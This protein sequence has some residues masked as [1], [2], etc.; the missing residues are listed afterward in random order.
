M[1]QSVNQRKIDFEDW[2]WWCWCWWNFKLSI[3]NS[4][5]EYT[6]LMLMKLLV[7]NIVFKGE[8][9]SWLILRIGP[10]NADAHDILSWQY[11]IHR[12]VCNADAQETLRC[13]YCIHRGLYN[14]NA[15]LVF[16]S[17][18]QGSMFDWLSGP[19]LH[20]LSGVFR[21]FFWFSNGSS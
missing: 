3:L 20:G 18:A 14:A 10:N 2:T 11:L 4:Q 5:G 13:Q 15:H 17:H 6:M 19:T 1:N 12:G 21:H 9:D 8:Y 7:V 16:Y